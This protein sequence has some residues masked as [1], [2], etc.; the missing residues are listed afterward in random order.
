MK[1]F[2]IYSAYKRGL[3]DAERN[4]FSLVDLI[5]VLIIV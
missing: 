3:R 1:D 2:L 5:W 4:T